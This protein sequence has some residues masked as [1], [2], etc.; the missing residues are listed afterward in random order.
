MSATTRTFLSAALLLLSSGAINAA[1]NPADTELTMGK[2][3]E[4]TLTG[5]K[6]HSYALPVR[7]G[8]Q[9]GLG[10]VPAP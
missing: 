1:P 10:R 2:S 3:E 5:N 8:D 6:G 9:F 4:G 7:A